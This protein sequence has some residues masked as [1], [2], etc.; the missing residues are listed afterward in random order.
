MGYFL[1]LFSDEIQKPLGN[2]FIE[3]IGD[4]H[5][6]YIMHTRHFL[7]SGKQNFYHMLADLPVRG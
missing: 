3:K 6:C 4:G 2:F 5:S 1:V 7:D